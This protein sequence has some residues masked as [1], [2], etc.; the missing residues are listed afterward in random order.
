M[1]DS[2][3]FLWF[4]TQDGLTRFDGY[5]FVNY[6]LCGTTDQGATDQR[7][8]FIYE[9]RQGLYWIGT[10]DGRLYRFDASGAKIH[11]LDDEAMIKEIYWFGTD[12]GGP[13]LDRP[14]DT[15]RYGY[16]SQPD[17][18][19]GTTD[20]GRTWLNAE[21]VANE[22]KTLFEDR[23]GNVWVGIHGL[24]E[25][26]N[27]PRSASSI[28]DIGERIPIPPPTRSALALLQ[29]KDGRLYFHPINLN[30]SPGLNRPLEIHAISLEVHAIAE[31]QYG[32][33]W[34]GTNQGLLHRYSN[35]HVTHFEIHRQGNVD[36]IQALL[37]DKEGRV[38]LGHDSGLFVVQPPAYAESAASPAFASHR[39]EA[40]PPSIRDGQLLLP[41]RGEAVDLT[42]IATTNQAF[43]KQQG[44]LDHIFSGLHQ[45]SNG[46]IWATMDGT[47]VVF[48]G[49]GFQSFLPAHNPNGANFGP[50][51]EDLDGNLWIASLDG[52]LRF[53]LQG[54]RTY[55]R[56]DGLGDTEIHRIYE[57]PNGALQVISG[58]DNQFVNEFGGKRFRSIY[59]KVPTGPAKIGTSTAVY[60][61][62]TG[63]W[64]FLT[65][66]GLYRFPPVRRIEDLAHVHPSAIYKQLGNTPIRGGS[67][68]FEDSKGNLWIGVLESRGVN[69]VKWERSTETF[70][71]MA[72]ALAWT[73]YPTRIKAGKVLNG[74]SLDKLFDGL[75]PEN[76]I[77]R[78]DPEKLFNGLDRIKVGKTVKGLD[79]PGMASSFA[80]DRTGDL[81]FGFEEGWLARFGV[82]GFTQFQSVGGG[83]GDIRVVDGLPEGPITA[84]H[85]DIHGRLWVASNGGGVSRADDPATEQPRFVHYTTR[86]G[87]F[88][89][90]ALC[91]TEDSAGQIYVG[92]VR[93]IDR[94]T[95][96]S[97][98]IRHYGVADGLASEIVNA[99]YRDRTG[100]LWFGTANGLSR[101]D[102]QPDHVSGPSVRINELRIAGV[103]YPLSDFGTSRIGGLKLNS[104]QRDLEIGF[105]GLNISQAAALRYQYKLQ[106]IDRDWSAPTPQ[107]S[108]IYA[109]LAPGSYSFW[110]RAL[111]PD[112]TASD[113]P[114]SVS[115]VINPPIWQRWWF[116]TLLALMIGFTARSLYVY[117]MNRLLALERVRT[118]IATD[119]HDDIGAGLSQ[120]SI[121]SEV[122]GRQLGANF[123][124]S[125]PLST[126]AAT[127]RELV[128]SMS[129]IVWAINPRRDSFSDLSH[130]IR[131][132]ASDVF[133]AKD[134]ECRFVIREIDR[135]VKLGAEIRRQ[136]F[137]IFKEAVNNIVR[138]SACANVKV[139]LGIE[140][141]WIVLVLEDDGKGFDTAL[142]SD[143]HGLTSMQQ[144]AK[145]VHAALEIS[146]Q[147]GRG[148]RIRLSVPLSRGI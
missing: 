44:K 138:H 19:T 114:A 57:D 71:P 83:P 43:A 7:I 46:R 116:L 67:N 146:S 59:T 12:N 17:N 62:H 111:A 14:W 107:R 13:Y 144:R 89:N 117:R 25:T 94:L 55:D 100:A 127:S 10:L 137:L 105:F 49:R 23:Q 54:F 3:G 77:D 22:F 1:R 112:G 115:F 74:L 132:F 27:Y 82:L 11:A 79:P 125:T 66:T 78:L 30:L 81:W 18:C 4:G 42:S 64:W 121:L 101:L 126:I 84:L 70:Y 96:G 87:L 28:L 38:W 40:H 122:L 139:D 99:A 143:G 92:T 68:I 76:M 93:G 108:V 104:A 131:R 102:P 61:D 86:E 8:T 75:H 129:D 31:G 120:I 103:P 110:V 91:I 73:E 2:Y 109:S 133:T 113:K 6:K 97:G 85:V 36:N 60:L 95:P 29:E 128:D 21:L 98:K 33:L 63:E 24:P 45:Q 142:P 9:T 65:G 135:R 52:P 58:S 48:D 47:L 118:R 32:S 37:V 123:T 148:T 136:I 72:G 69:L 26:A 20:D 140:K 141:L 90:N 56:S 41:E 15:G 51:V 35:G 130:R 80:E 39:L 134:I 16:Q 50:S 34:L 88:S 124:D 119:L 145:D 106:D 53:S 5:K 147:I